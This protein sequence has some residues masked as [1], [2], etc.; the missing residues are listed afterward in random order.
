MSK[1][2][3]LNVDVSAFQQQITKADTLLLDVRR[4]QDREADPVR[5]A[6][7]QWRDPA[8]IDDWAGS[9]DTSKS[10]ALYCVRGGSVSQSVSELLAAKGFNVLK[11][12]GGLA[13]W[14]QSGK[15]VVPD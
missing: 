11:F 13:A 9:L 5:I 6:D 3:V 8:S 12:E 4:A 15:K 14:K 1:G 10:V 7:A 2:N